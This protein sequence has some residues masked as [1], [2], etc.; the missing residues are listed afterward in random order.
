M[1][2]FETQNTSEIKRE[3]N[4]RFL[5]SPNE[6]AILYKYEPEPK[7]VLFEYLWKILFINR[8]NQKIFN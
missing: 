4:L 6:T 1:T 5:L 3:K 7:I 2:D 8:F